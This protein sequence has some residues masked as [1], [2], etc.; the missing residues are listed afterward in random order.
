MQ[1]ASDRHL[2]APVRG[3]ERTPGTGIVLAARAVLRRGGALRARAASGACAGL[4]ALAAVFS[5][6]PALWAQS[7]AIPLL[8]GPAPVRPVPGPLVPPPFFQ[9]AVARGTRSD[10][11]RPGPSYWQP[12]TRTEMRARAY[13]GEDASTLKGPE[14]VAD[15]LVALLAEGFEG[16]HR[17]R[18]G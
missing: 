14:V 16:L 17:E 15:R 7:E 8:E 4:L 3:V 18:V 13:P 12:Y 2:P 1:L 9:A 11:G 6:A 5:A 10:D